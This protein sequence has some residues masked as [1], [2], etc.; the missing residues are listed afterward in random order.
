MTSVPQSPE[1]PFALHVTGQQLESGTLVKPSWVRT[2]KLFTT[3]QQ[4]V[5][6]AV[7]RLDATTLGQV[8]RRA[9][10]L[11]SGNRPDA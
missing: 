4:L 8:R 9:T 10:A 11:V 1:D 3:D 2:D 7:A 5:R 6:K